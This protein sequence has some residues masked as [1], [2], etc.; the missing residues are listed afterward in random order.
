MRKQTDEHVR[1]GG[2]V[3]DIERKHVLGLELGQDAL[4]VYA[5]LVDAVNMRSEEAAWAIRC[6]RKWLASLNPAMRGGRQDASELADRAELAMVAHE[7][8][9]QAAVPQRDAACAKDV[10]LSYFACQPYPRI[11]CAG[12][13]VFE[14]GYDLWFMWLTS[15]SRVSS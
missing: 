9:V 5:R 2:V 8:D 3:V 12:G 11:V 15:F 10:L 13:L 1:Q 4:H 7:S 6:L 14:G